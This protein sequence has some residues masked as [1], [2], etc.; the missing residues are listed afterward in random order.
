M[1][2]ASAKFAVP[3]SVNALAAGLVEQL[4]QHA[5]SLRVAVSRSESGSTLIDAGINVHGGLEVGRR[6]AEICM[7]GLGSVTLVPGDAAVAELTQVHVH[8][9]HPVIACLAS[10]YAGWSLSH[11]E[12][13]GA[14]HALASG[15]GRAIARR[16]PLFDELGYQDRA[17]VAIFVLEVDRA[18]PEP[19]VDKV[20]Q[21]C[22]LSND[23]LQFILTPTRSIAGCVQ[24]VT[25]VVEVALHKLHALH[26]PLE[27]LVDAA[28]VA[29]LPPPAPDFVAAMGRTNDAI[30]FGGRVQLYVDTDDQAAAQLA[31]ALPCTSSRDY[32]KPFAKIFKDYG[33]DF[34]KIDPMLFAPAE[35][36]VCNVATGKTFKG[37]SRD[38]ARLA[39]S[40]GL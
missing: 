30:L 15:P 39:E 8:T 18:P 6:V 26:F 10:Q 33:Y 11:G 12:G 7:G 31:S 20:A 32:G 2:E 37:G 35:V 4:I 21:A 36:I 34:Y 23:K 29:P 24:I 5:A 27:R 1:T 40:F 9:E 22:A 13:K 38:S 28:G 16:E 19:I 25:R 14:F 17:P 3:V